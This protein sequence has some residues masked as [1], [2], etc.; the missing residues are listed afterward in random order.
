[1]SK[2]A[3]IWD[4][5]AGSVK[6]LLK[7]VIDDSGLT[8][9]RTITLRDGNMKIYSSDAATARGELGLGTAATYNVS[10]T[11]AAVPLLDAGVNYWAGNQNAGGFYASNGTISG[12]FWAYAGGA[13]IVIGST[14]NNSVR[15]TVNNTARAIITT[16]GILGI[17]TLTP[18]SGFKLDVAGSICGHG[19]NTYNLGSASYRFSDAFVTNGVTTGSDVNEKDAVA[20]IDGAQ[21]LEFFRRFSAQHDGLISWKW[22]DKPEVPAKTETRM[23]QEPR[24]VEVEDTKIEIGADGKR[25]RVET[26]RREQCATLVAS[27]QIVECRRQ[28]GE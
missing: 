5:A 6:A 3:A 13:A 21:W 12:G 19:D 24:M 27:Q 14:T 2:L 20:A 22:K 16:D 1:M 9:Q 26:I 4:S 18:N 10:N 8:A 28:I 15:F 23:R 11:G 17:G 7:T 25:R